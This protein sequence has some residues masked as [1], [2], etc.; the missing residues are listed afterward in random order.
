MRNHVLF[1]FNE[2]NCA[3]R[4]FEAGDAFG[5]LS[6]LACSRINWR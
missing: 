4:M 6:L 1:A 2:A 3:L 5:P